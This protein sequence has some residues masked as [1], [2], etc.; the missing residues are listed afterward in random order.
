[1]S[2][3]FAVLGDGAW[4]T[5]L[6]VLFAL[7]PDHRVRLWSARRDNGLLMQQRRERRPPSVAAARRFRR[8]SATESD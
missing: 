2:T 3:T 5:A 4:G 6:A 1:M 7:R 8:L